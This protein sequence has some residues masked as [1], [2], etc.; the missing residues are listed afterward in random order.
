MKK[1]FKSLKERQE[2]MQDQQMQ[3]KQQELEQQQQIAQA[4]LAQSQ[5]QHDSKIANDNYEAQ[6]D[7]INKVQIAMIAAEAKGG[8]LSDVD[9]SGTADVL[10]MSK[11]STETSKA[12]KEYETK[13]ADIQNKNKIANDKMTI[14][15]E[16]LQ[17]ERENQA[18]DIK[19]AEINARNRASKSK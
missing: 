2:Q 12:A 18:N 10:E 4:Q 5:Q 6:L 17:V 19:V 3:Q 13:M 14:E 8:P 11:L 16:K 7:R 1:V 15:R 9:Q